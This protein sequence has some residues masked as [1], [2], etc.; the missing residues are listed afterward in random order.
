VRHAINKKVVDYQGKD[1]L[2]KN[3]FD[4]R[5]AKRNFDRQEP[6]GKRLFDD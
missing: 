6:Y 5:E 1:T 4:R 3:C 2:E